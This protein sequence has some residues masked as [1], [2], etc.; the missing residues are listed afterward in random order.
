MPTPTISD[1]VQRIE[2]IATAYIPNSRTDPEE[3]ATDLL[4]DLMHFCDAK[5]VRFAARP[6]RAWF[7]KCNFRVTPEIDKAL[8]VKGFL[9]LSVTVI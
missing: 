5:G 7:K 8:I 2:R 1:R 6:M 9:V 4:A 3:F